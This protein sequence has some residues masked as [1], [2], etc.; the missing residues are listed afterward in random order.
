MS[1]EAS[2]ETAVEARVNTPDVFSAFNIEHEVAIYNDG[3]P[4]ENQIKL[5]RL[6]IKTLS[7]AFLKSLELKIANYGKS[8]YSYMGAMVNRFANHKAHW[9]AMVQI[10]EKRGRLPDTSEFKKITSALKEHSKS[11]SEFEERERAAVTV[12]QKVLEDK[13]DVQSLDHLAKKELAEVKE[14]FQVHN[15]FI[16]YSNK[17]MVA[18]CI[19]LDE[20]E[21]RLKEAQA[22]IVKLEKRWR[23]KVPVPILDAYRTHVSE[24]LAAV[25]RERKALLKSIIHRL[26]MLS[27]GDASFSPPDLLSKIVGTLKDSG[28]IGKRSHVPT[29]KGD[30]IGKRE[31]LAYQTY[32][33]KHWSSLEERDREKLFGLPWYPKPSVVPATVD[34]NDQKRRLALKLEVADLFPSKQRRLR[35]FNKG[36]N[37]RAK[38]FDDNFSQARIAVGLEELKKTKSITKSPESITR[39]VLNIHIIEQEFVYQEKFIESKRARFTRGLRRFFYKKTLAFIDKVDSHTQAQRREFLEHQ[40]ALAEEIARAFEKNKDD[41]FCKTYSAHADLSKFLEDTMNNIHK[42]GAKGR[43]VVSLQDRLTAVSATINQRIADVK[44]RMQ[45]SDQRVQEEEAEMDA[46]VPFFLEDRYPTHEELYVL[47]GKCKKYLNSEGLTPEGRESEFM[48]RVIAECENKLGQFP[49]MLLDPNVGPA[50]KNVY[51][52]LLNWYSRDVLLKRKGSDGNPLLKILSKYAKNYCGLWIYKDKSQLQDLTEAEHEW[53]WIGTHKALIEL[54]EEETW[55]ISERHEEVLLALSEGVDEKWF[56]KINALMECR[57]NDRHQSFRELAKECEAKAETEILWEKI[58]IEIR[59]FK[60]LLTRYLE[61]TKT[62]N[63]T[64]GNDQQLN[65]AY[66]LK[67]ICDLGKCEV[68][69]GSHEAWF[70]ERPHVNFIMNVFA[71][72]KIEKRAL[73]KIKD[74]TEKLKKLGEIQEFVIDQIKLLGKNHSDLA[75]LASAFGRFKP[76]IALPEKEGVKEVREEHAENAQFN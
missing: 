8:K 72:L 21:Q 41:Q 12:S 11:W 61:T 51:A 43:D 9:R 1:T 37:F 36:H 14:D 22:E 10:A 71:K 69:F 18:A 46:L 44:L 45:E 42:F 70:K 67:K 27:D 38:F 73:L 40:I 7:P 30:E 62:D 16:H 50:D 5:K 2:Q 68:Q 24:Q 4:P 23:N 57:K 29:P 74:P 47:L 32:L 60:K 56:N 35:L 19:N 26:K 64:Y 15:K 17:S 63:F 65:L 49:L 58:K 52:R 31:F 75:A 59:S 54:R 55:L 53:L 20:I 76:K 25:E 34:A 66:L 13:L 6:K 33:E 28:R 3:V 48:G 39:R